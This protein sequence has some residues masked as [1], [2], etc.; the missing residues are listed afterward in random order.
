MPE[1]SRC[2]AP[3]AF[4]PS[5]GAEW[6]SNGSGELVTLG[7]DDFNI[8]GLKD[9]AVGTRSA[10]STGELIILLRPIREGKP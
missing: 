8:D 5:T 7:F 3:S 1:G 2:I 9:I 6:S 4:L 10:V